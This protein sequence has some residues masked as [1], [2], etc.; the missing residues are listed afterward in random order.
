MD[1]IFVVLLVF[2]E[3]FME[4]FFDVKCLIFIEE[5]FFYCFV[6]EEVVVGFLIFVGFMVI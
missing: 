4:V 1:G 2:T 5:F 6:V 3:F